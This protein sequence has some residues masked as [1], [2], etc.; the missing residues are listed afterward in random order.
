MIG[1]LSVL[2]GCATDK[3]LQ[4]TGGSRADGTVGLASSVNGQFARVLG[5]LSLHNI[6]GDVVYL[7]Q[8]QTAD[9]IARS[10]VPET[11]LE[12]RRLDRRHGPLRVQAQFIGSR[13]V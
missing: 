9:I 10:N 4:A 13:I 8:K 2:A 5:I 3:V 11:R 7:P 1:A 12:Q 6:T